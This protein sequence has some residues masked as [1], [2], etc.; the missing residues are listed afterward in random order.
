MMMYCLG[1]MTEVAFLTSQVVPIS[2]PFTVFIYF[3]IEIFQKCSTLPC[4]VKRKC[5]ESSDR[6]PLLRSNNLAMISVRQEI[7][8]SRIVSRVESDYPSM[9]NA[10]H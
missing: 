7:K 10:G 1:L 9:L 8:I 3:E 2:L 5:V 6:S 4:V